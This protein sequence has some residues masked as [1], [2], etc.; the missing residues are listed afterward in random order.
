MESTRIRRN[1]VL[2]TEEIISCTKYQI[3]GQLNQAEWHGI[4]KRNLTCTGYIINAYYILVGKH[5]GK[6]PFWRHWRW[7]QYNIKINLQ[8]TDMIHLTQDRIK[9]NVLTSFSTTSYLRQTRLYGV[10]LY[11]IQ[12]LLLS[13]VK[14]PYMNYSYTACQ[15]EPSDKKQSNRT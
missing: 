7:W 15:S 5:E 9:G 13:L 14:C 4:L 1:R 6:R 10:S 8:K 11:G 2:N 12:Y 3:L